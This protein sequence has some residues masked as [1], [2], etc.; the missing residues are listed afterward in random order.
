VK[1]W[2]DGDTRGVTPP[3][4]FGG[5]EVLDIIPFAGRNFSVQLSKAPPGGGGEMHHHEKWSQMFFVID[6]EMTFDTGQERFTLKRGE[7][8]LFDPREPHH[9]LNESRKDS[10]CLVVTVAQG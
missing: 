6:G 8:V 1:I 10:L 9:T 3:N 7:S 4:H 5:L 2:K